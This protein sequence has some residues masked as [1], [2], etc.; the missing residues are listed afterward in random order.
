MSQGRKLSFGKLFAATLAVILWLITFSACGR[1]GDPTGPSERSPGRSMEA[2][3]GTI[4]VDG[5]STVFPIT[6]AVAEEFNKLHPGVRVTVGISGTGGGFQKFTAGEIDISDASRPIKDSE[7]EGAGAGGVEYIEIPVA[8]DGL[9]VVVNRANDWVD[10]LTV[11]ELKKIWEPSSIVSRWNQVRPGWPDRE[12]QLF[13]PGTDS[14]TFDY[15]TEAVIGKEDASRPDYTASEDDHVLVQG[16][17]GN[18]GALGYF[19]YAYYQENAGRIKAVPI[20]AGPGPVPPSEETINN[21]TYAPL[22]RPIFIYV[23]KE[24]LKRPE[25]REFVRFYLTE[26][27]R[28]IPQVGYIPLPSEEYERSLDAIG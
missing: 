13:G 11:A 27:I 15:F 24:S 28:L 4:K 7:K 14:G 10:H 19:G 6:E 20:D 25:V 22:A 1:S 5:S 21:G 9:S 18:R 17:A 8:F 12:I 23:N 26:G 3:N 16:V 2:L